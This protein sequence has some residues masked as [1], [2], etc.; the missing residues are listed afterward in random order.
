MLD[1]ISGQI[2]LFYGK[3]GVYGIVSKPH[4]VRVGINI[5]LNGFIPDENIRFRDY[6]IRFHL[7]P[8]PNEWRSEDIMMQWPN[9]KKSL[10]DFMLEAK[11][12]SMHRGQ[13]IGIVGANG[14][15]K[16][17]FVKTIAGIIQPSEGSIPPTGLMISYKP[18]YV[19]PSTSKSLRE[20]LSS[21]GPDM[22]ADQF[23]LDGSQP[24]GC[25]SL[26]GPTTTRSGRARG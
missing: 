1:Y 22:L 12:G 25:R 21:I 6:A 5:Y 10:G 2:C 14:T 4:R 7:S 23:L 19:V 13:V 3:P 9:F 17:T 20:I 26:L 18:Q 11:P 15:G 16:T 8:T 24:A